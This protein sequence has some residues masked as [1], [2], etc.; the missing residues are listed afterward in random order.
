MAAQERQPNESGRTWKLL[1]GAV[2]ENPGDSFCEM[3]TV[4]V[5][6]FADLG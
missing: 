4:E 1:F 3:R 5:G 2:L 6:F